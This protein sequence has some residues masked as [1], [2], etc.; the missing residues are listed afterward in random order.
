M[1]PN[2]ILGGY[3]VAAVLAIAGVLNLVITTGKGAPKNPPTTLTVIGF[4][5]VVFML[6]L[7]QARKRLLAPFAA[8]LAALGHEL[9]QDAQ[10]AR[11]PPCDRAGHTGRVGLL[12]HATQ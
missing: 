9:R 4:G 1:Q 6:V 2:E 3:V 11:G 12:G 10:R 5:V 7:I 8:I